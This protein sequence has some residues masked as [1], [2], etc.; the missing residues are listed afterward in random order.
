MWTVSVVGLCD[1]LVWW[2]QCVDSW[3]GGSVCG[4]LVWC[5]G[6]VCP[7]DV[8]GSVCNQFGGGYCVFSLCGGASV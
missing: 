5:G 8:M 1:Q 3:W 6:S 4:R 7:V 2:G